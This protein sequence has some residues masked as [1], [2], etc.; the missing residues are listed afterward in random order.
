MVSVL[1]FEIQA[2]FK[3]LEKQHCAPNWARPS[4]TV[5][6]ESVSDR[7]GVFRPRAEPAL[8]RSRCCLP[9]VPARLRCR[10]RVSLLPPRA[11]HSIL[12]LA[13]PYPLRP[14][15]RR[16][17]LSVPLSSC[18]LIPLLSVR[19]RSVAIDRALPLHLERPSSCATGASST[20]QS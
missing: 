7:L 9:T 3:S 11:P 20:F 15:R 10:R 13:R 6:T 14:P 19:V 1:Y 2:K 16:L 17:P 12:A 5:L 8:F 18:G 4:A